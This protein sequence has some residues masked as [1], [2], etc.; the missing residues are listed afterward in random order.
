MLQQVIGN[1]NRRF[2]ANLYYVMLS[3]AETSPG[4]VPCE[5]DAEHVRLLLKGRRSAVVCVGGPAEEL[6]YVRTRARSL[7]FGHYV[8]W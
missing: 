6:P 1:R 8:L 5:M 3:E 2:A 7:H 4:R